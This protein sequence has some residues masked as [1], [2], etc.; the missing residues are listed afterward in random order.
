MF[1]FLFLSTISASPI[2]NTSEYSMG[3]TNLVNYSLFDSPLMVS[4]DLFSQIPNNLPG[5]SC[6]PEC[7][8]WR[9]PEACTYMGVTCPSVTW[10]H[11]IDLV[12]LTQYITLSQTLNLQSSNPFILRIEWYPPFWQPIGKTWRIK[13][14]ST[15]FANMTINSNEYIPHS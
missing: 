8:R 9:I 1:F 2:Y 13:L 5:W 14:N 12:D 7:Y 6:H 10:V 3:S 11:G 15:I 4:G